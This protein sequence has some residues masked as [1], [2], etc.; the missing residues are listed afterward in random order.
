MKFPNAYVGVRK[1][2]L[3]EIFGILLYIVLL[4]SARNLLS[5]AFS[6]ALPWV[7]LGIS[8]VLACFRFL[9]LGRAAIDEPIFGKAQLANLLSFVLSVVNTFVDNNYL[10][11]AQAV[12]SFCVML[13]IVNG[14]IRLAERLNDF[15]TGNRGKLVKTMMFV[16]IIS[17]FLLLIP[18]ISSSK[19]RG[20]GALFLVLAVVGILVLLLISYVLYLSLLH[21]AKTMLAHTKVEEWDPLAGASDELRSDRSESDPW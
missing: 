20:S 1:L 10:S 18:A 12:A 5:N 2:F 9:A 15:S 19:G 16:L 17:P 8:L 7:I 14:I 11:L 6:S 3:A 21:R 4:L 13:F